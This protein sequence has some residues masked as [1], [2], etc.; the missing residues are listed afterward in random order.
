[1]YDLVFDANGTL[2]AG[3]AAVPAVTAILRWSAYRAWTFT[4]PKS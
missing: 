1:M 3:V 2:V 4:T